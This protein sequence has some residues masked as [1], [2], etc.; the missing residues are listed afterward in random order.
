[1]DG[2][3]SAF[4]NILAVPEAVTSSMDGEPS[5]FRNIL[6]EP[7]A[8]TSAIDGSPLEVLVVELTVTCCDDEKYS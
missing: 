1:M 7:D 4:R 5:A 8:V 6:A 3:P 2:E